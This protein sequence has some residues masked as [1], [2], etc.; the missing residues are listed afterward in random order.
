MIKVLLS[1]QTLHKCL[2][3]SK[4]HGHK[5]PRLERFS[6]QKDFSNDIRNIKNL[7]SCLFLEKGFKLRLWTHGTPKRTLFREVEPP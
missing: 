4:V 5:A 6:P 2:S 1:G 7:M 3:N